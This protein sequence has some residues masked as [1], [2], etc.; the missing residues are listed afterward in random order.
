[1]YNNRKS[2]GL[3]TNLQ[4]LKSHETMM[5]TM[6]SMQQSNKTKLSKIGSQKVQNFN[7]LIEYCEQELKEMSHISNS[8]RV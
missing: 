6:N 3:L 1:M 4:I 2:M 5:T 7:G 8:L